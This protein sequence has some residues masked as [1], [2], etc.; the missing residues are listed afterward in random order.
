VL[1]VCFDVLEEVLVG[2]LHRK[3]IFESIPTLGG[4]GVEGTLL[5]AIIFKRRASQ[6]SRAA[7]LPAPGLPVNHFGQ[8][9]T[10][11]F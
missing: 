3:S 6:P 11:H 10:C 8:A 7:H 4:G 9:R 2:S 5:G 1:L